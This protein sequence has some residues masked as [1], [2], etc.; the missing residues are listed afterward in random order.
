MIRLIQGLGAVDVWQPRRRGDDTIRSTGE[1]L[2][3]TD[4]LALQGEVV[5]VGQGSL[6]VPDAW[7][8]LPTL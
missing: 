4:A 2:P 8:Q 1:H 5:R 6:E 3:Q 7:K